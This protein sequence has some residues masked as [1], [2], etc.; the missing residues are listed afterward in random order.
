M[1][2]H[3]FGVCQTNTSPVIMMG[4]KSQSFDAPVLEI[5]QGYC[6]SCGTDGAFRAKGSLLWAA[7]SSLDP[8]LADNGRQGEHITL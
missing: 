4:P 6:L 5:S 3:N 1:H 2:V 7:Y 8:R